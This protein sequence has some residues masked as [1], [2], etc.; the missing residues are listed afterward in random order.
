MVILFLRSRIGFEKWW[1]EEG[2]PVGGVERGARGLV[3]MMVVKLF[4][5]EASAF[6]LPLFLQSDEA[7]H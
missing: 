2:F 7:K 4:F 5:A 6:E 1:Q 3:N